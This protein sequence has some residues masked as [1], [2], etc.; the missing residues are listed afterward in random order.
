MTFELDGHDED[1]RRGEE[2]GPNEWKSCHQRSKWE[3]PECSAR[4]GESVLSS[5]MRP[6][7]YYLA[8]WENG[9]RQRQSGWNYYK[10]RLDCLGLAPSTRLV[11]G[12]S[13]PQISF[14][15]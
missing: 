13:K 5:E 7:K 9:R 2:V 4:R 11:F 3:R 1:E 15:A 14:P 10:R 12:P 8:I 6:F